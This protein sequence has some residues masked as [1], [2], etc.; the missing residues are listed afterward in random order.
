MSF[1]D[2]PPVETMTGLR[3][4]A[5]FSIRTQSFMSELA[6]L[7]ISMPS[8]THRSTDASSNGVAIRMQPLPADG[9]DELARTRRFDSRV[10]SVFLM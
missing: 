5:I 8:S 6:I 7:M 10:S 2:A 9:L 4:L 3:V 1:T